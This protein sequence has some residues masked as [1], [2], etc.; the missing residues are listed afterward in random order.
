[1][2]DLPFGNRVEF[3][4]GNRNN[5]GSTTE[6][7]SLGSLADIV[8]GITDHKDWR[9]S[10]LFSKDLDRDDPVYLLVRDDVNRGDSPSVINWWLMTSNV[11]TNGLKQPGVVPIKISHDDW[12]KN[13]GRNWANAP[14]LTGQ[15]HHFP[16][17]CGVDVGLYIATPSDPQIVTDAASAGNFPYC[18]GGRD[19]FETQQLLRYGQPAGQGYLT[20]LVPRWPNTPQPTYRT[21]KDGVGV[22]IKQASGEDL[23]FLSDGVINH[24]DAAVDFQ[25]RIGFVRHGADNSLRLMVTKG[26]VVAEGVTLASP[27]TASLI[28]RGGKIQVIH[29]GDRK[30]VK[31]ELPAA[32]KKLPVS[33]EQVD[34]FPAKRAESKPKA[35]AEQNGVLGFT[36]GQFNED[37]SNKNFYSSGYSS[38]NYSAGYRFHLTEPLTLTH[39]GVFDWNNKTVA[40]A[41]DGLDV[42]VYSS[43]G[44]AAVASA[45]VTIGDTTTAPAGVD[46]R[47]QSN[48]SVFRFHALSTPV[49]LG[50]G[51]YVIISETVRGSRTR[52]CRARDWG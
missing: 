9:R 49:T 17:M 7:A 23:L 39:L 37:G 43:D 34:S 21:L 15:T 31:L 48:A 2:M 46:G 8:T 18:A 13:L 44:G 4:T 3:P 32:W 40:A 11:A 1:M 6:F 35:A 22:A 36:L 33:Y 20:L 25:G 27:A 38:T 12:V 51:T 52:F 10:V 19:L 41:G 28:V 26:R 45:T 47:D 24:K 14:K 29:T 5:F 50:S 42:A 30:D 16:G